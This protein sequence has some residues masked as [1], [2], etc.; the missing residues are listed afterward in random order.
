MCN[1]VDRV[2][3]FWLL[4]LLK[5][6]AEHEWSRRKV[7]DGE[8]YYS[9]GFA[10]MSIENQCRVRF[11]RLKGDWK[12]WDEV[13][14]VERGELNFE[15][16]VEVLLSFKTDMATA[17]L[18]VKVSKLNLKDFAIESKVMKSKGF[19]NFEA[20]KR[21]LVMQKY[22]WWSTQIHAKKKI[23]ISF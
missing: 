17:L 5:L 11:K 19:V 22:F 23:K 8:F 18:H 7:R 10:T 2:N 9:M 1:H 20:P 14:N 21:I 13:V 4:I 6:E 16:F 3:I 15:K 12:D